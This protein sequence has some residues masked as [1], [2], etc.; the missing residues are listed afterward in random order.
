MGDHTHSKGDVMFSYRYMFMDMQD[1]R[2]STN[3]LSIATVLQEYMLSPLSMLMHMHMLGAMYAPS[4]K[5]TIMLMLNYLQMS[6]DHRTRMGMN[7]TTESS[8]LADSW[9]SAL[10]KVY[11]QNG[12]RAHINL[13]LRVPSGSIDVKGVSPASAPDET[14]LPYPMQI[15]SGSW[16]LKPGITYLLEKESS[17]MGAQASILLPLHE[18]DRGYQLAPRSEVLAWSAY[19]LTNMISASLRATAVFQGEISGADEAYNMAVMNRMVPTVFTENSGGKWLFLGGGINFYVPEGALKDVRL[20][21][22][23][24]YPLV[25][26]LNGTQMETKQKLT[27]G[28]QYA[29]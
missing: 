27:L 23:Y 8:G 17:S 2:Q 20:A 4:D 3:S 15:G 28:V 25:Q 24:E 1:M 18:N 13:G 19:H 14:Q 5:L 22:E 26:D 16:G 10:Y 29:F 6:M 7:F 9:V 21:M 11:D 12:Q